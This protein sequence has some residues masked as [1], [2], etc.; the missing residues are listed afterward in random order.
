MEQ[1]K[2]EHY[3]RERGVGSFPWFRSL[4]HAECDHISTRIR[5]LLDVAPNATDLELVQLIE[6]RS[7]EVN[8]VD[9]ESAAFNLANVFHDCAL[10][11]P[12]TVYLNWYRFDKID[13]MKTADVIHAFDDIWYPSSN[14]LDIF[15]PNCD[16][17]V[18]IR[19]YGGVG[20]LPLVTQ[21]GDSI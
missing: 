20:V 3:E 14:D 18:S 15:H 6:A 4:S 2:I 11:K 13:E 19:H 17:L 12:E 9:A 16:W 8:G 7:R 5:K 21:S 1:F 10:R